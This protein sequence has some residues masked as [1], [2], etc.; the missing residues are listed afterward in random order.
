MTDELE[1]ALKG[2]LRTASQ[3]APA[4]APDLLDRLAHRHRARR[5]R[6]ALSAGAAAAAVVMAVGGTNLLLRPGDDRGATPLTGKSPTPMP[7]AKLPRPEP[8]PKA[9]VQTVPRT[10]PNG[11]RYTVHVALSPTS[12]LVTTE[13]SFEKA[14]RVWA[15]DLRTRRATKITD[16]VVP[17]GSTTFASDFTVGDG[18]IAWWLEYKAGRRFFT[19]IWAAPLAGGAAR[20]V[21]SLNAASDAGGSMGNLVVGGGMVRWSQGAFGEGADKGVYEAP[22]AG[23]PVRMMPGTEGHRILAWP[24]IGTPGRTSSKVGEI[25]YR[26]LRN[27]ETGKVLDAEVPK[28]EVTW[29]CGITW[30][31]GGGATGIIYR[32]EGPGSYV[33]RRDGTAARMFVGRGVDLFRGQHS[34]YDRFLPQLIPGGKKNTSKVALYDLVSG[35]LLELGTTEDGDMPGGIPGVR[36]AGTGPA[37]DRY[38]I[39]ETKGSIKV[40]DLAAIR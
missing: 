8:I 9:A 22:L 11:R 10:L 4:V 7:T 36:A 19:E 25:T 16:V 28:A 15:Y 14:D 23:G 35:R 31:F 38:A 3:D 2:A 24:W 17:S 37:L 29:D 40:V 12:L 30:C 20:K 1:D 27:V 21:V 32:G 18:Q 33:V 39:W 13:S 26:R 6:R 5:R 34:L